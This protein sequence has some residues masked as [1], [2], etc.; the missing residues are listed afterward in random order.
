[1][2]VII[3]NRDMRNMSIRIQLTKDQVSKLR[4]ELRCTERP[5]QYA[6]G[7]M[8]AQGNG[9]YEIMAFAETLS[10]SWFSNGQ[11]MLA[12]L[13]KVR[14]IL[15]DVAPVAPGTITAIKPVFGTTYLC[16]RNG[17]IC[18]GLN[19]KLVEKPIKAVTPPQPPKAN[20]AS[21][22]KLNSLFQKFG[23]QHGARS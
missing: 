23:K 16:V 18:D 20:V 5:I 7:E 8:Y 4:T 14:S 21:L 13:R 15:S 22:S 19:H 11:A 1:M 9:W 17:K 3:K 10:D 12:L 6:C 2:K